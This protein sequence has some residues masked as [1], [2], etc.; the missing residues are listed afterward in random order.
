MKTWKQNLIRNAFGSLS[1]YLNYD[2]SNPSKKLRKMTY[3]MTTTLKK[4]FIFQILDFGIIERWVL[5]F[6]W[7]QFLKKYQK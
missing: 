2:N 4:R 5:Q 1:F 3:S 7:V 6:Q